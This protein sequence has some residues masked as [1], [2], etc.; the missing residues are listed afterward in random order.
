MDR[1][2]DMQI[3]DNLDFQLHETAVCIGKFDGIHKGHRLLVEEVKKGNLIPVMFTFA[4]S[5]GK[6]IYSQKEKHHLAEELGIEVVVEIPFDERFM[7]QSPQQFVTEVL[8]KRCGAK[9]VVVGTDFRFGHA[10][11][12]DAKLLQEMGKQ[13]GF[14]TVIMEKLVEDGEVVSSTKIRERI[15]Q[16]K[17]EEANALLGTP[18]R[19]TGKVEKGNQIG[20]TIATPTANI[21]PDSV[22][23]L[24]PYGV[25]AV[26][27]S[28][29]GK[30]YG[31]ISNL[32]VKPTISANNAV[33]L[34]T[35]LFDASLNLYDKQITVFLIAFQR[36]EQKFASIESLQEQIK[37]DTVQA[38]E[39]LKKAFC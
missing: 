16:G 30:Q 27:V 5:G 10:R 11:K 32:G 1:R 18:Y 15:R 22:K 21:V 38:K 14:E 19:I 39:L 4:M 2:K 6:N 34:E 28:V 3:I 23:E 35:W 7:H 26:I 20:R 31:G 9:K 24:P 29:E 33:G 12:G 25:Y 17:I 37:E 36:P 13:Y 8:V